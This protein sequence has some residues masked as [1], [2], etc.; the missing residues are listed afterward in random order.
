LASEAV[1]LGPETAGGCHSAAESAIRAGRQILPIRL[2]DRPIGIAAV[3][4][5]GA[6]DGVGRGRGNTQ[7]H[8]GTLVE[9]GD[10]LFYIAAL[11]FVV[12]LIVLGAWVWR[13]LLEN[14]VSLPGGHMFKQPR[15]RRIGAVETASIDGKRKLILVRRDNV[16]HLILTGGPIDLVVETGI[17]TQPP[18]YDPAM[19]GYGH[20]QPVPAQPLQPVQ[21][22]YQPHQ[23]AGIDQ[24]LYGMR[25]DEQRAY[26]VNEQG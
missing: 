25:G 6:V 4:A 21:P 14:G 7:K 19:L 23:G 8:G 5:S 13:T 3:G 26:R 18:V 24:R 16:E 1:F 17:P 12:A 11:V 22:A 20:P 15:D 10:I 9:M 2:R